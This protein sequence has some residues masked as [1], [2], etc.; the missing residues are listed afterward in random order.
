M[1]NTCLKLKKSEKII[2]DIIHEV[3][4][5]VIEIQELPNVPA[6]VDKVTDVV[7]EIQEFSNVPALV[8]KVTDVVNEIQEL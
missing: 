7:N 1:G 2:S 5:V 4:D 8:D 6:L 3:T